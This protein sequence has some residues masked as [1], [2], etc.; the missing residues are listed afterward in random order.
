MI[1]SYFAEF[2]SHGATSV[3]RAL[4]SASKPAH[5]VPRKVKRGP[6]RPAIAK[7]RSAAELDVLRTSSKRLVCARDR[8]NGLAL[9]EELGV[10][11]AKPTSELTR[12]M[13]VGRLLGC[14][15][16]STLNWT[17][18]KLHLV[19]SKLSSVIA[20]CE[21]KWA[22]QISLDFIDLELRAEHG[23]AI[24]HEDAVGRTDCIERLVGT[25]IPEECCKTSPLRKPLSTAIS[26]FRCAANSSRPCV[27]CRRTAL[28]ALPRRTQPSELR[29][30]DVPCC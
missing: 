18:P 3:G 14:M 13:A 10:K 23:R 9:S 21:G 1:T 26:V 2:A 22:K 25:S 4:S 5:S 16:K 6:V 11:W 27:R 15:H 28:H 8:A 29:L 30:R 24:A 19:S 12:R 7:R 17:Q 20:A